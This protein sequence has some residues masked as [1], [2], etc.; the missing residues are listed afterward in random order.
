MHYF[1][2]LAQNKLKFVCLK[3]CLTHV[4]DFKWRC[5]QPCRW[6]SG[7]NNW[8]RAN[9]GD[10]IIVWRNTHNNTEPN[11]IWFL[12]SLT[13]TDL[14]IKGIQA[15]YRVNG[16]C[17][18]P[19]T[20]STLWGTKWYY[21]FSTQVCMLRREAFW[22]FSTTIFNSTFKNCIS[23]RSSS[24]GYTLVCFI[25]NEHTTKCSHYISS[26][27]CMDAFST[28]VINALVLKPPAYQYPQCWLNIDFKQ[29]LL[30]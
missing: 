20:E 4:F 7:T 8:I 6:L 24:K 5:G 12:A 30:H 9:V 19:A 1:I 21:L 11:T 23:R 18:I 2:N 14:N 16:K 15:K 25:V 29:K 26:W 17:N 22:I 3:L 27:K 10:V 13:D 28:L